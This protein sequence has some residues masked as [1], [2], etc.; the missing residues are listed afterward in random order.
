MW[1]ANKK[2]RVMVI[3]DSLL[4][5]KLIVDGLSRSPRIEVVGTAFNAQDAMAKI[6]QMRPDVISC[7]VE[8]PGMSGI[9]FLKKLLPKYKMPVILGSALNLRVF[10]ALS[11]WA[12]GRPVKVRR[13]VD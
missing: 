1:S 7:D 4:A 10:D 13:W 3:D 12:A 2:I 9:E 11:E 8:M 5:R 6:P